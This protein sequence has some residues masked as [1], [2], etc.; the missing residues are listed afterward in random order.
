VQPGERVGL[1]GLAA[2]DVGRARPGGDLDDVPAPGGVVD[3]RRE[4]LVE[5]AMDLLVHLPQ[6]DG[7]RAGLHAAQRAAG[8]RRADGRA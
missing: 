7:A 8:A 1:R 6:R 5:Q 2:A 3:E 4:R